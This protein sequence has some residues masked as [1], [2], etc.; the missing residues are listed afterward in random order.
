MTL[1]KVLE[2]REAARSWADLY[3]RRFPNGTYAAAARAV[4]SSGP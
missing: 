4:T 1:V 2:G 3:L